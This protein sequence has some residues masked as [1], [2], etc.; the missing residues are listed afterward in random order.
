MRK[1][2][3]VLCFLCLLAISSLA[4]ASGA[5]IRTYTPFADQDPAAQ[6]YNDLMES[7]SSETGNA[8]EDFSGTMDE[9]YMEALGEALRAGEAD[10]VVLPVGSG[11]DTS[12]LIDVNTLLAAAPDSGIRIMDG[13]REDSGTFL[14]P[15]RF[16]WESIYVNTEL[17]QQYGMTAPSTFEELVID[18][19][20]LS[21]L[22]VQPIANALCEWSEIVLDCMAMMGAP[23]S[24]YGTQES[25]D[26]A[27]NVL[28]SLVLVGAFGQDPWNATDMDMETRFLNGE[29]AMRFDTSD[30][31]AQIPAEKCN[32]YTVIALPGV[33]GTLRSA[34]VGYPNCGLAMTKACY[35]DSARR[36]AAL[37][38]AKTLL[39]GNLAAIGEG[40]LGDSINSLSRNATG[41]V[42]VL[43]DHNPETFEEWSE[44]VIA[45]LMSSVSAVQ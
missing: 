39:A 17:L 14:T 28:N 2:V 29:A 18:C 41:I 19:L 22:G 3:G 16:N 5:T 44:Q 45:Q 43:Y 15:V 8:I 30:L 4:L 1:Y 40:T 6:Q 35:E 27:V 21:Q 20:Q 36:E 42:G 37:S 10:I 25:L 13:L 38:F 7:W 24:S 32:A 33:D 12:L 34:L 26:G 31:A 23:E 11:V 9:A